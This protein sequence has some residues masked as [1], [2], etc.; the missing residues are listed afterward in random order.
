MDDLFL[1]AYK[2]LVHAP[3]LFLGQ[4]VLSNL[5]RVAAVGMLV[6]HQHAFQSIQSFM[7]R[8]LDAQTLSSAPNREQTQAILQVRGAPL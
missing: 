2:G 4:A 7:W 6:Q 3:S 1:M 5:L 8:L